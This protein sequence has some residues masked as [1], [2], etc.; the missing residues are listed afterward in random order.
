MGM[1]VQPLHRHP[2]RHPEMLLM[3]R[4]AGEEAFE[5]AIG[6]L[7][8][9]C[10]QKRPVGAFYRRAVHTRADIDGGTIPADATGPFR[11][12]AT[13]VRTGAGPGA[14]G[15]SEPQAPV[16]LQIRW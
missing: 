10:F 7:D 3:S 5:A 9:E 6:V 8:I 16:C 14:A 1:A 13:P 15:R 11:L 4:Q 12:S 2:D